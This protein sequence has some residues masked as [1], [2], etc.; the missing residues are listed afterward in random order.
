[1]ARPALATADDIPTLTFSPA[2][3]R[4]LSGPGLRAFVGI[5]DR[6]GLTEAER[7][8]VLGM[9]GRSTFFGWLA[10]AR[11]GAALSLPFDTLLRISALLGVWKALK[12]L[13]AREEDGIAWL[14]REN[15]GPLFGGQAPIALITSG[16][17]DGLMLVRR[18]LD[19]WRGGLF[20]APLPGFDEAVAPLADDDIVWA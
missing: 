1:M 2:E 15:S 6:L 17:Q 13:F 5:A 18:H 20:S 14:K 11:A 4:R 9:P 16:T 19:A 3:R 10:K 7:M 8:R 12:I